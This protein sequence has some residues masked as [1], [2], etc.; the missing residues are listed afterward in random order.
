MKQ[1]MMALLILLVIPLA[2]LSYAEWQTSMGSFRCVLYE[3]L[4]P[5][6]AN[7]FI[8]LAQDHFYDGCIFHRVI[9]GFMIQDGDPTGTGYGGPGWTI[10]NEIVPE[11]VHDHP[12]VLSMAN[13]GPNT[14]GSQ[15]Y[16]TVAVTSWLDGD[17]SIFGDVIEGMDVVYAISDVPTDANDRPITPVVIDSIRVFNFQVQSYAPTEQNLTYQVGDSEFFVVAATGLNDIEPTFAW[18][19]DGQNVSDAFYLNQTFS[20]PGSFNLVCTVSDGAYSIDLPWQIEVTGEA[21]QE[22]PTPA[23]TPYLAACPNPF[24]PITQLQFSMAHAG[25]ARLEIFDI[26]GRRVCTPV[27]GALPAGLHTAQ[28]NAAGMP[29][30]VYLARLQAGGATSVCKLVLLK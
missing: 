23:L 6:T 16:I 28:W 10:P 30:G 29:S 13:A 8:D 5:I 11:L 27:D 2:A 4:V 14:G 15:Y 18:S 21:V 9:D 7:N 3:N 20:Q 24:Q 17:Y 25:A 22:D 19:L 1:M 12:G 26:R